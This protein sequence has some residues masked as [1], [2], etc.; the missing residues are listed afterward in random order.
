MLRQLSIALWLT[1]LVIGCM[2]PNSPKL[3]M[4]SS[5]PQFMQELV[6]ELRAA[7]VPFRTDRDGMIRYHTRDESTV[8]SIAE[9]LRREMS[10]GTSLKFEGDDQ[11]HHFLAELDARKKKSRIEARSDG[12]WIRWYPGDEIESRELP[13]RALEKW[14]AARGRQSAPCTATSSVTGGAPSSLSLDKDTAK[15]RGAC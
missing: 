15:P 1:V 10:T 8:K 6:A 7:Q 5:D 11:K 9:Q 4:R 12:E 13:A 14:I 3:G 2:D